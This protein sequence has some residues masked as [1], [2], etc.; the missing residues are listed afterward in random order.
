MLI[1]HVM[2]DWI[3]EGVIGTQL[4]LGATFA[5]HPFLNKAFN[6]SLKRP[7]GFTDLSSFRKRP[8]LEITAKKGTNMA[9]RRSRFRRRRTRFRRRR[10][11]RNTR[12]S[13]FKRF[14]RKVRRVVIKTAERKKIDTTG[15]AVLGADLREGDGTSRVTYI[16]N[17]ISLVTQGVQ[18]D[19][20]LGNSFWVSGVAFRGQ[21]GLSEFSNA[22]SGA[23]LKVSWVWSREQL[24]ATGSTFLE[25]NSGTTAALTATGGT[26]VAP[27]DTVPRLFESTGTLGFVGSGEVIPFN[28]TAVKVI[29]SVTIP[30]NPGGDSTGATVTAPTLFNLWFPLKRFMQID[31]PVEGDLSNTTLRFKRGTYYLVMQLIADT[32]SVLA[33]NSVEMDYR[34][35]V[36][37]RDP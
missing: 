30:V 9:F 26:V 18:D 12:K 32:N 34:V 23:N 35:T 28:G 7:S 6:P 25:L 1:F 33:A 14:A 31:D 24:P 11:R 21:V 15:V 3:T 17:P 4:R 13:S 19:Q 27:P 2:T 22:I 36:Y 29:K 16:Y 10:F 5:A 20:F 37:Y 8:R